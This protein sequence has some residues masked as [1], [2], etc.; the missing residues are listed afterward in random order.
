MAAGGQRR[1][2]KATFTFV[3]PWKGG[4]RALT[5][6]TRQCGWMSHP[7]CVGA[8]TDRQTPRPDAEKAA[9]LVNFLS[10]PRGGP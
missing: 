1:K 7:C 3:S 4:A 2:T 5:H 10:R 6:A 8:R 9:T